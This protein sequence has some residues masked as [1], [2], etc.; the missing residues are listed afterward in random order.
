VT[1]TILASAT[2]IAN[3]WWPLAAAWHV[4]VAA[5]GVR[6]W[7]RRGDARVV[8]GML[9]LMPLSVAAMA[10]WSGNPINLAM[11][12]A[13]GLVMVA[14]T[15]TAM[16]AQLGGAARPQLLA[17]AAMCAFGLV[18]PHFLDRPAWHYLFAA[19]LGL[20]PC[21]TLAFLLGAS[22]LANSFG[23]TAWAFVMGGMGLLYGLLGVFM[24]HV[25]IDWFLIAGAGVVLVSASRRRVASA[26]TP[27]REERLV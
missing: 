13:L 25:A 3:E 8:A 2:A 6:L 20:L 12:A 27:H 1:A 9:S 5:A 22:L 26:A 4:A 17:G 14:L 21:P 11:F 19:P 23:S 16:T 7:W 10:A 15:G 18:Y 24:L